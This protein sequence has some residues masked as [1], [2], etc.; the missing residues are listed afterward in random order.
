MIKRIH[1]L[2]DQ[3]VQGKRMRLAVASAQDMDVLESVL[4]A[5][6]LGIVTPVLVGD[7]SEIER[8]AKE[9]GMD[10]SKTE[11]VDVAGLE[12]QANEAVRLVSEGKADFLMKGLV[13]TS[14]ILKA[15]LKKEYGLRTGSLLSHVMVYE[16]SFYDKLLFLTDGGMNILPSLEEKVSI[17]NNA[18]RCT[19]SFGYPR[20]HVACLAA[21]EK[22]SEK[23]QATVDAAKL[24]EMSE[25]GEFGADVVVEGPLALDIAISEEAAKTKGFKSKLAG[26]V[27]ILLVPSIE[28]GNGI[29][30]CM[31]YLG[32]AKS[33]G[34]IVGAKVPVV[35]TSRADSA[36]I[37]LHSIAFGVLVSRFA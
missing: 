20:T 21:K 1:E 2:V 37:K 26:D 24:Q 7:R 35:M 4:E 22:V 11:I 6:K 9:A 25:R 23:M 17:I 15:L 19:R 14:I 13:D 34:V 3:A 18:V 27:D 28:M 5:E 10:V 8:L 31:T 12:E 29:G 33:A 36:E 32:G 30:K 16:S